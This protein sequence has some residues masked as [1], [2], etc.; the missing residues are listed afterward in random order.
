MSFNCDQ[1]T[2]DIELIYPIDPC[3][4]FVDGRPGRKPFL[5]LCD[6]DLNLTSTLVEE[7]MD[8]TTESGVV[9]ND[10]KVSLYEAK[11]SGRLNLRLDI[12]GLKAAHN[13]VEE[14]ATPGHDLNDILDYN[15]RGWISIE[16][17][18][19]IPDTCVI[20][21][22]ANATDIDISKLKAELVSL[23]YVDVNTDAF[24]TEATTNI[25]INIKLAFKITE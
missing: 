11:L 6:K 12:F 3:Y 24:P 9:I 5:L 21:Y 17:P 23:T 22:F 19:L 7:I 18:Y 14:G 2:I 8:V 20:G 10:Y 1:N 13:I 25:K 15:N 4:K 16:T